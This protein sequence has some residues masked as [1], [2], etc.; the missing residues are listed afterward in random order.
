Y[1]LRAFFTQLPTFQTSSKIAIKKSRERFQ[2]CKQASHVLQTRRLNSLC[3]LSS[4]ISNEEQQVNKR[5]H[6]NRGQCGNSSTEVCDC[7]NLG[8]NSVD[9]VSID[10]SGIDCD[11]HHCFSIDC[12]D[13]DCSGIDCNFFDCGWGS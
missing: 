10:C 7:I 6:F 3:N 12:N 2:A 5:K 13:I 1:A 9:Y 11:L 8:C 4:A